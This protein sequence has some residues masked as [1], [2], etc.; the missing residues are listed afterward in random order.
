LSSEDNGVIDRD[1]VTWAAVK[2]MAGAAHITQFLTH[3]N[4]GGGGKGRDNV[5]MAGSGREYWW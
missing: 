1:T 5:D 3:G 4:E 2:A